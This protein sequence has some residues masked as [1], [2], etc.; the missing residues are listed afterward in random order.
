[1]NGTRFVEKG[2]ELYLTCNASGTENP[3]DG[4]DWF[5]NGKYFLSILFFKTFQEEQVQK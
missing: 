2:A 1:M 3:P 5:K 4:I